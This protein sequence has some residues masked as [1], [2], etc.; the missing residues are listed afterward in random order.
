MLTVREIRLGM[1]LQQLLTLFPSSSKRKEMRDALDRAK[2]TTGNEIVYLLFDPTNDGSKERF[3]G[4]DSIWVGVY[5]GQ[6]VD[7]T[8]LYIGATWRTVDEWVEKLRDAF[9]LPSAQGWIVGSNE[10][11]SKI[12]KCKGVE[13]EAGIQG[14]SGTIRVR[15]TE[16]RGKEEGK[17]SGEERKRQEFKP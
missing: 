4:I 13:I 17:E 16:N 3:A 5:K 7:F 2:A 12:L 8:V 11:P 6:V 15:N 14:G 1:S 9:G 10:N